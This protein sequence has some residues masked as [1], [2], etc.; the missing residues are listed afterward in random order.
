MKK[1]VMTFVL[2][3]TACMMPGQTRAETTPTLSETKTDAECSK[4]ILLSYFPEIFVRE[5]LQKFNVPKDKWDAIVTAL[6]EKNKIVI[7]TVEERASKLN[8]SLLKDPQQRQAAV[9]L[10][11]ETILEIFSGVMKNNGVTDEKQIQAMLDDIQQQTARRF[12]ACIKQSQVTAQVDDNDLDE[13][14]DVDDD[15]DDDADDTDDQ[16]SAKDKSPDIKVH[17]EQQ[18]SK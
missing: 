14:D 8:V 7:K 18:S 2:M 6:N 5:T 16:K 17:V 3:A 11:R 10:F 9:K 15:D 4:D 13:N 12:A 1:R